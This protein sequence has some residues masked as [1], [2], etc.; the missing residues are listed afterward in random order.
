MKGA[1][2][3]RRVKKFAEKTDREYRFVASHGKGS[4]GR[5]YLGTAFTTVKDPNKEIGF[6]LLRSMCKDLGI[7]H[8]DI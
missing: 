4:H 7:D 8:S 5:L 6:G 3:L 1:E 2:F